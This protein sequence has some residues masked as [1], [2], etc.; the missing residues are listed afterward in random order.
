MNMLDEQAGRM[1]DT[2]Q[3]DTQQ[4]TK[5]W[6]MG[7]CTTPHCQHSFLWVDHCDEAL[8]LWRVAEEPGQRGWL[9]AAVEPICPGCG[10]DL[11]NLSTLREWRAA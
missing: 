7:F 9:I 4:A 2:F 11:L 8:E 3:Q 1:M 6:E 10:G 5:T